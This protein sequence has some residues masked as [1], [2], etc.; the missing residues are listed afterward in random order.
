[1]AQLARER[2]S[3]SLTA[4]DV[5]AGARAVW[6]VEGAGDTRFGSFALQADGSWSYTLDNT[7]AATQAL[8]AGQV[9][10]LGYPVRVTDEHGAFA[11]SLVTVTVTGSNDGA[12]IS[13]SAIGSV[14]EA[15]G[16]NNAAPGSA[17]TG[18][19]LSIADADAVEAGFKTRP[20][21]AAP[22]AA[23]A[24]MRRRGSGAMF[25]TTA[26]RRRKG[27]SRASRS[28][29][30]CWSRALTARPAGRSASR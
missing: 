9:V 21:W 2:A 3:G 14:T 29:T 24:L 25:W 6:S 19:S 17:V 13:G 11:T 4:S 22:M 30:S 12:T 28:R 16:V 20:A 18:G 1:M 27:W 5:D 26:L 15:G 23:S 8:V 10:T 7:L